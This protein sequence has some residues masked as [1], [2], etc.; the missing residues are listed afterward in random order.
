MEIPQRFGN[1]QGIAAG[2]VV[3]RC[4]QFG[5][6]VVLS[7]SNQSHQLPYLGLR[8]ALQVEAFL[9]TDARKAVQ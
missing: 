3:E 4:S 5:I 2:G 9:Q 8:Q 7:P 6:A 1:K